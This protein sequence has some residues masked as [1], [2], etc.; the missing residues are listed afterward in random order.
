[1]PALLKPVKS[2]AATISGTQIRTAPATV[3]PQRRIAAALVLLV[4]DF[5]AVGKYGADL[6]Y[7]LDLRVIQ[8]WAV[9][10]LL[11]Q[12]WSSASLSRA[13]MLA[14]LSAA[15]IE[16]DRKILSD[17]AITDAAAF[18]AVVSAAKAALCEF[19]SGS[20]YG[21]CPVSNSYKIKPSA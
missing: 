15:G 6:N 16:V 11:A 10:L 14:G 19:S 3:P 21:I 7:F 5:A 13:T 18:S 1:M 8:A 4:W 9:G 17:L 12:V 20:P 2:A